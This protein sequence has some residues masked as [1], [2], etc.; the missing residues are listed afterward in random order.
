MLH[1]VEVPKPTVL[2]PPPP[3]A[4]RRAWLF[5]RLGPTALVFGFSLHGAYRSTTWYGVVLYLFVPVLLAVIT[6]NVL[7]SYHGFDQWPMP[8]GPFYSWWLKRDRVQNED[9]YV[10]LARVRGNRN[11]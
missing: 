5:R 7:R 11:P 10:W 2:L 3:H 8:H 9:Y 6:H 1:L 4:F